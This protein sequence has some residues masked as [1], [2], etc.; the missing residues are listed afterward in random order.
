ML[1]ARIGS[2]EADRALDLQRVSHSLR[3]RLWWSGVSG[4]PLVA[5]V[6]D[7][8]ADQWDLADLADETFSGLEALASRAA[9]DATQR[10]ARSAQRLNVLLTYFAVISL[11]LAMLSFIL[12]LTSDS[13]DATTRTLLLITIGLISA[14]T[15]ATGIRH[16]QRPTS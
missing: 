11:A 15:A 10:Q 3:S 13:V 1:A 2:A 16:A 9:L 14:A 4:D 7:A 8:V 6:A 12:D 5:E